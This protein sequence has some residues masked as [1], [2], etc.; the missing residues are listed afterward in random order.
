MNTTLVTLQ[1]PSPRGEPR[2]VFSLLW[3]NGVNQPP[4]EFLDG[5]SEIENE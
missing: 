2:M 5:V 3:K 4:V 1:T